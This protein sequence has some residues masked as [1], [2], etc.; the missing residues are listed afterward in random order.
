MAIYLDNQATTPVD[1]RVVQ[2][3]LPYF[4]ERFGNASSRSHSFGWDAE[5]AVERSRTL[6]AGL[7]GCDPRDI[8]FTSGAT[9]SNN[10]ALRGVAE[11]RRKQGNH[12]LI[13]PIEHPSVL[14][15]AAWL[16]LR[17][18]E[19][20]QLPV[21]RQG[22][23]APDAVAAALRPETILVSIMAANNEIGT[24]QPLA[25]I[26]RAIS[27]SKAL[28]HTDA[29]QW[30]G[31][32]PFDVEGLRIHLVSCTA[33]KMYGP[34]GVG[35]LY[36]RRKNPE[37]RLPRLSFGGGQERGM[38]AGTLNVPGIV[39]F[40]VAAACCME[41]VEEGTGA[42][43]LNR[44]R[45]LLLEQLREGLVK[46]GTDDLQVNGHPTDRIPGNLHLTFPGVDSDALMMAMPEV[47]ISSG[48]AC[49]SG[50][51]DPSH[52]LTAIGMR[53]EC[54]RASIRIGIGRFNTEEEIEHVADLLIAAV[55]KLRRQPRR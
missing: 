2:A 55:L 30:V 39:G 31:K 19:I 33:H 48:S 29:T 14:E 17:G 5:E 46:D 54:A 26:G 16:G 44:L 47:A 7:I 52:V 28:F 8:V 3:M 35:A 49:A 25:E 34:K 12:I 6:L 38:R 50:T 45:D 53:P 32:L 40:G 27:R 36:V 42:A 21:D 1:P 9:E 24:C 13:S 11:M 22:R 41:E 4:T 20:E 15:T 51:L 37:I 23:V 18:F 10:L 43:K